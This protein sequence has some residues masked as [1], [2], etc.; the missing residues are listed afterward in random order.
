MCP[1]PLSAPPPPSVFLSPLRR[2][3][4][5]IRDAVLRAL[6]EA[7]GSHRGAVASSNALSDVLYTIDAVADDVLVNSLKTDWLDGCPLTLIAEGVSERGDLRYGDRSGSIHGVSYRLIVDPID[8]TRPLMHDKRAGW[9]LVGLARDRGPAEPTTLADIEI[10]VMT[11]IPTSR[12]GRM[13]QLW[14]VRGQ[15]VQGT[16]EDARTG[17]TLEFAVPRPAQSTSLVHGFASFARFVP[18]ARDLIGRIEE[19]FFTRALPPQA[20]GRSIS[21]EDQYMSTGGQLY[22]L[23]CGRDL[24]I[25]DVRGLLEPR[26]REAGRYRPLACHPYDLAAALIAQEAG[27]EVCAPDG[28]PLSYPLDTTTPC[29]WVGYANKSLR[30][31]LEPSLLATL[32]EHKVLPPGA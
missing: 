31:S 30:A 13:D 29:S 1:P 12:Q 26:L 22:E 23:L 20:D 14:A 18:G 6:R 10:A 4:T 8:G 27:V 2:L 32:R 21:F 17:A 9:V 19:D 5:R 15:G 11:E 28:S 24:F 7:P 25:A 16:C 3:G